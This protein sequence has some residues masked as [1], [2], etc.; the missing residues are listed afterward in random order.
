MA[1][2]TTP[3]T[4]KS[5]ASRGSASPSRLRAMTSTN[6]MREA[7]PARTRG[8]RTE[9]Q[10]TGQKHA[11]PRKGRALRIRY[12]Y[13]SVD[14]P[15]ERPDGRPPDVTT[16]QATPP[17][18]AQRQPMPADQSLALAEFAR[19]CKAAARAVSLYPGAHPAI[20][21]SLGRLVSAIR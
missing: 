6:C 7:C 20:G 16:A 9:A 5:M 21:G 4:K 1:P 14:R 17:Q 19:A 10:Y 11:E 13:R 2:L 18:P 12:L 15:S 8:A 3:S